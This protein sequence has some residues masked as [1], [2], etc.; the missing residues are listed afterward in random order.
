MKSKLLELAERESRQG[1]GLVVVWVR[2]TPQLRSEPAL[3]AAELEGLARRP[4][5]EAADRLNQ[6]W[7]EDGIL[8]LVHRGEGRDSA[9]DAPRW[10]CEEIEE[11]RSA[12]AVVRFLEAVR[13][14]GARPGV[15]VVLSTAELVAEGMSEMLWSDGAAHR[16]VLV[17]DA[18]RALPAGLDR[19][20][21]HD[22]E[23]QRQIGLLEYYLRRRW[24]TRVERDPALDPRLTEQL[25][26]TLARTG[27]RAAFT[28]LTGRAERERATPEDIAACAAS[29]RADLVRE[30]APGS[31]VRLSHRSGNAVNW[32]A[33]LSDQ[34]AVE[35]A[36]AM[37]GCFGAPSPEL[38]PDESIVAVLI[39][40]LN[41]IERGQVRGDPALQVAVKTLIALR[42]AYRW[43]NMFAHR[44]EYR[45][46]IAT[47]AL[48]ALLVHEVEHLRRV[49]G[50]WRP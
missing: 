23:L 44:D 7:G 3:F 28:S 9:F 41:P 31:P 21:D 48:E 22:T 47:T 17:V 50:A 43:T 10:V 27:T 25:A 5:Q 16:R 2:W 46:H 29:I 45:L 20:V 4:R 42:A 8:T 49:A 30:L 14:R 11:Q 36:R 33:C 18:D 6:R 19:L 24:R 37:I 35:A 39:A 38:L 12:D 1:F 26:Q 13:A 40:S 32:L 15:V 34:G